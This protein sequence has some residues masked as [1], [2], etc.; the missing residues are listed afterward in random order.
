[1]KKQRG[2]T[3]IELLVVISIIALL[4]AI[5]L[6]ALS[7]ARE[8]ARR[9]VCLSNQRQLGISQSAYATDHDDWL[10]PHQP[11]VIPPG[12]ERFGG[13]DHPLANSGALSI[14]ENAR[15]PRLQYLKGFQGHGVL[16]G[17]DYISEATILYC[18]S[19]SADRY[20]IT[21]GVNGLAAAIA[22][23]DA[24]ENGSVG[25]PILPGT[26][27]VSNTYQYRATIDFNRNGNGSRDSRPA[28]LGFEKGDSS[29]PVNADACSVLFGEPAARWHHESSYNVLYLDGHANSVNDTEEVLID[30]AIPT[31][32]AA[33]L[34]QENI[35]WQDVFKP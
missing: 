25:S 3:L 35:A 6:P 12:T 15:N 4:I 26:N 28:R 5:L 24:V 16:W 32:F 18:P 29:T 20:G 9:A 34:R 30:A 7:A 11:N 13:I 10:P 14:W 23:R 21:D 33:A 19:W 17:L 8:S 2:F 31:S 27:F 1:M 22:V